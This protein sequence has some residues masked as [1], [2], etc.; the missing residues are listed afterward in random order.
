MLS[1]EVVAQQAIGP[2]WM[3][4]GRLVALLIHMARKVH[5][6]RETMIVAG[7]VGTV[8]NAQALMKKQLQPV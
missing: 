1:E 7:K 3:A 2:A 8:R 5:N 6:A 4:P